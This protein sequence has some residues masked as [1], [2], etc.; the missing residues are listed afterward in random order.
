MNSNYCIL[1]LFAYTFIYL[2][3]PNTSSKPLL[4]TKGFFFL[5]LDLN[6]I[7]NDEGLKKVTLI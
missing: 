3:V 7:Q 1:G 5:T 6:Q 2:A 4:K